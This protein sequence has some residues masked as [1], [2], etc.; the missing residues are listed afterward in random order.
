M[1]AQQW[2]RRLTKGYVYDLQEE[3]IYFSLPR[4]KKFAKDTIWGYPM[5]LNS[6]EDWQG[7][8][9]L[10]IH[11][12]ELQLAEYDRELTEAEVEIIKIGL[13]LFHQYFGALWN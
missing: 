3:I 13:E 9:A 1:R 10:I 5:D 4:L 11:A 6:N 2:L 7:V 8:L 12:M